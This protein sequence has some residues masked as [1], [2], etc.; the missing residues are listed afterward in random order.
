MIPALMVHQTERSRY[1]W[2]IRSGRTMAEWK[3]LHWSNI[4]GYFWGST[5]DRAAMFED[6][7]HARDILRYCAPHSPSGF[8]EVARRFWLE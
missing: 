5:P 7:E 6:A 1:A 3:W 2:I 8:A 4:G